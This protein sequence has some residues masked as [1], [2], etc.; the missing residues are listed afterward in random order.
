MYSQAVKRA[1]LERRLRALE[2]YHHSEGGRHSVW[3]HPTKLHK[4]YIPRHPI[5]NMNTARSILRDAE[6]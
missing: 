3:A 4:L 5:V 6:R 1:E 2:W